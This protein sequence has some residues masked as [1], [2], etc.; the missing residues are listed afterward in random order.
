VRNDRYIACGLAVSVFLVS[1]PRKP[2]K[3]E[4]G[5]DDPHTELREVRFFNTEVSG[6]GISTTATFTTRSIDSFD[7][8]YLPS[9]DEYYVIGILDRRVGFKP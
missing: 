1:I 7:P 4:Y 2:G 3:E 9:T 5:H 6:A 8:F